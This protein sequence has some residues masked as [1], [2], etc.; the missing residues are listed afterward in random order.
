MEKTK[1]VN[2]C[3]RKKINSK[4]INGIEILGINRFNFLDIVFINK[5]TWINHI[6]SLVEKVSKIINVMR[7]FQYI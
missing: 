5:L 6:S 4:S 1:F 2:F 3:K 7:R